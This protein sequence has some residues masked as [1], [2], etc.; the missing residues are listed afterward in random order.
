MTKKISDGEL[1]RTESYIAAARR[2]DRKSSI[3]RDPDYLDDE[4]LPEEQRIK[5]LE[6]IFS[7]DVRSKELQALASHFAPLLDQKPTNHILIC[8]PTGSGKTASIIHFLSSLQ[9]LA[10]REDTPV[11]WRYVELSAQSTCFA[12][13]NRIAV[14]LDASRSYYKGIP[15]ELMQSKI[16]ESLSRKKGTI[17][18]LLDEIDCVQ[19]DRD[20]FMTYLIKTL[21]KQVPVRLIYIFTTNRLD[22]ERAL[23]AR[24][25]SCMKKYDLIFNPYDAVEIGE[26]IKLRVEKALNPDLVDDSALSLIAALSSRNSGDARKAVELLV[27][28]AMI[29]DREGK[30]LT[31]DDVRLA[32]RTLEVE[33]ALSLAQTL[34]LHQKLCLAACYSL[35][36]RHKKGVHTGD[37]YDKYK[38]LAERINGSALSQRRFSD[39]LNSLDLYCLIRARI[40]SHGRYGKTRQIENPLGKDLACK[41][42]DCISRSFGGL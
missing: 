8:G 21:Q 35:I 7:R 28:S 34:P 11:E 4:S 14:S 39:I 6:E 10:E 20:I 15:V 36:L 42:L 40:V 22:W 2:S 1:N 27:K 17:I 13:L 32:E 31:V 5:V 33:K 37:V 18:F 38:S 41:I 30:R 29:A 3:I 12:A 19:H 16:R 24:I 26:I 9:S 25:T 23:D